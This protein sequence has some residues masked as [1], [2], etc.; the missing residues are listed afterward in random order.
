M[1][2]ELNP[3]PSPHP[4]DIYNTHLDIRAQPRTALVYVIITRMFIGQYQV[5]FLY[6]NLSHL[7]L[8]SLLT[9]TLC[10]SQ[11]RVSLDCHAL[12]MLL[13]LII[14]FSSFVYSYFIFVYSLPR[15][16]R[17]YS[18]T[19]QPNTGKLAFSQ[20]R[21]K[22]TQKATKIQ[23]KI[24]PKNQP[25]NQPKFIKTWNSF[26]NNEQLVISQLYVYRSISSLFLVLESF[27]SFHSKK[28]ARQNIVHLLSTVPIGRVFRLTAVINVAHST[29]IIRFSGFIYSLNNAA[30]VVS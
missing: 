26:T 21:F 1:V 23:L 4:L 24:Q 22:A 9:R 2:E 19:Y 5:Y 16:Q 15:Y 12:I 25:K 6:S 20:I 10:Y 13:I 17:F 29:K 8:K 11:F 7:T 18:L 30:T 14:R 27:R 28:F 3:T